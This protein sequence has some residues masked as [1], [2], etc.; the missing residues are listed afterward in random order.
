M[1]EQKIHLKM[2]SKSMCSHLRSTAIR[3]VLEKA[4][5]MIVE[6]YNIIFVLMSFSWPFHFSD[7]GLLV[8]FRESYVFVL[9]LGS[10]W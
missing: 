3:L 1:K 10:S 2:E 6:S 9:L 5:A 4:T 8:V 7:R